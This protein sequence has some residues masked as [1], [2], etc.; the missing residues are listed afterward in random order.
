MTCDNEP[1]HDYT[2][3]DLPEAEW[4]GVVIVNGNEVFTDKVKFLNIESD[5]H[6]RDVM[7]FEYEG[8]R[9]TSLIIGRWV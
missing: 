5:I 1:D 8:E 3:V 9:H 2:L 6:G 7:T 4:K